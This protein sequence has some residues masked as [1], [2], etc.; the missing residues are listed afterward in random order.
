MNIT[1]FKAL[2]GKKG[3]SNENKKERDKI[4]TL[5]EKLKERGTGKIDVEKSEI[6][7]YLLT[8]F[9]FQ[10]S[11]EGLSKDDFGV[12]KLHSGLLMERWSK[13][14]S[15]EILGNYLNVIMQKWK[16]LKDVRDMRKGMQESIADQTAKQTAVR[17]AFS[18]TQG[19]G[20]EITPSVVRNVHKQI[21]KQF[22]GITLE[23]VEEIS[24]DYR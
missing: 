9:L 18:I 23:E 17:A 12:E 14:I 16:Q 10:K 22:P 19:L 21:K 2:V 11:D 1:E 24:K 6:D 8:G 4:Y 3:Y 20:G 15:K 13:S 7:E 5:Y